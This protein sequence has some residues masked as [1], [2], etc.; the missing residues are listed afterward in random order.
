MRLSSFSIAAV[1]A[2]FALTTGC[3]AGTQGS[4]LDATE[5]A[6]LTAGPVTLRNFAN[7]PKIKEVRAEVAAV[8]A[9]QLTDVTKDHSCDD[10]V[11]KLTK[12]TDAGGTIRKIFDTWGGS[13]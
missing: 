10:A 8:D 7:H 9:A 4:D 5:A 2:V 1:F 3:A 13:D 11:A 6:A 12:R